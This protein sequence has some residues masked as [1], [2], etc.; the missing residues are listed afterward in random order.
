VAVDGEIYATMMTMEVNPYD[1]PPVVQLGTEMRIA[2]ARVFTTR[3]LG[4]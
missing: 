4:M 1:A 3:G 2:A